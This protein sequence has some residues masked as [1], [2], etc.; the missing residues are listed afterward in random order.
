MSWALSVPL[1]ERR[2]RRTGRLQQPEFQHEERGLGSSAD[3][4]I[5]TP[6]QPLVGRPGRVR[7]GVADRL[8]QQTPSWSTSQADT[9]AAV[10]REHGGPDGPLDPVVGPRHDGMRPASYR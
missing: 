1:A 6:C 2:G 8:G 3:S 7:L 10:R 5:V 4:S 9:R